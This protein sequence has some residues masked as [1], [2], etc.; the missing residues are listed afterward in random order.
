M[1]QPHIFV[2]THHKA[3]TVW[4]LTT[5]KRLAYANKFR[6]YDLNDKIDNWMRHPERDVVF[7]AL[8]AKT[9]QKSDRPAVFFDYH[10]QFPDLTACKETPGAVGLHIVRDPR[11][12]LLSAVRFHLKAD[13]P[14]LHI[15]DDRFGG[16]T[17]QQKLESYET[18]DDRIRFEMDYNMGWVIKK[19][20][21]FKGQDVFRTVRYEDLIVDQ[22]LVL[23]HDICLGLGLGGQELI[24]G[25]DAFWRSSVFGGM[26]A[27][28]E[29]GEHSHIKIAKPRQWQTMLGDTM[30]AEIEKRFGT[31]IQGLGYELADSAQ[32]V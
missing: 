7:E 4:M 6:F 1:S 2:A 29:S 9:E 22:S 13:E 20:L 18:L 3:G 27:V 32:F 19:M 5:F 21:A 30:I 25:L 8:R 28:A 15:A 24:N 17:Y 14:W 12:M 10:C 23:W 11:D 16:L 26:K 31:Q